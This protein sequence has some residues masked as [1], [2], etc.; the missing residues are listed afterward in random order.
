MLAHAFCSKTFNFWTETLINDNVTTCVSVGV[1]VCMCACLCVC[2]YVCVRA[3]FSV[4]NT[5][6][7]VTEQF[8]YDK[9]EILVNIPCNCIL[10]AC[11]YIG[12]IFDP[13]GI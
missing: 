10:F 2:V 13:I 3:L 5:L 11:K 8:D 7:K 12:V 6:Y 4:R 1:R 9:S